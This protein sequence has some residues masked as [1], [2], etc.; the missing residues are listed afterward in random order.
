MVL[1]LMQPD[2]IKVLLSILT[3]ND[4]TGINISGIYIGGN[5][6]L[7]YLYNRE[8]HTWYYPKCFELVAKTFKVFCINSFLLIL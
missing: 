3:H 2:Q 4:I 7:I 8:W 1:A 5:T 6:R